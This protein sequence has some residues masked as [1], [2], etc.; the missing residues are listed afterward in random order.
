VKFS[1]V[2]EVP[3]AIA[4]TPNGGGKNS[5]G[6]TGGGNAIFSG[7]F[8]DAAPHFPI[9]VAPGGGGGGGVYRGGDGGGVEGEN[10][11][12]GG[13]SPVGESG[14]TGG[15]YS[16]PVSNIPQT[17]ITGGP[18]AITGGTFSNGSIGGLTAVGDLGTL[19]T[20]SQTASQTTDVDFNRYIM[21][22]GTLTIT[23]PNFI[24]TNSTASADI[25]FNLST[26]ELPP[27]STGT[28]YDGYTGPAYIQ[29][30]IN[31]PNP[32]TI[33]DNPVLNSITP[34]PCAPGTVTWSAGTV[35]IQA[36]FTLS[37]SAA[38]PY[39]ELVANKIIELEGPIDIQFSTPLT[40]ITGTVT[41]TG[42]WTI[43]PFGATVSVTSE[44]TTYYG[45][46]GIATYGATGFGNG[47]AG[48]GGHFGGGGGAGYTGNEGGGGAGSFYAITGGTGITGVTY[49]FFGGNDGVPYMNIYNPTEIYGAGGKSGA[50]GDPLV[51]IEWEDSSITQYALTV[52][53]NEVVSGLA[54]IGTSGSTATNLTVYGNEVINGT[55]TIGTN[56]GSELVLM[57]GSTMNSVFSNTNSLMLG[58]SAGGTGAYATLDCLTGGTGNIGP[59]IVTN[60]VIVAAKN[61]PYLV[62]SGLIVLGANSTIVNYGSWFLFGDMIYITG[63]LVATNPTDVT[64]L[65]SSILTSPPDIA[66]RLA[67]GFLAI[68]SVITGLFTAG[69]SPL[70]FA[71]YLVAVNIAAWA[72]RSNGYFTT[73]SITGQLPP[74]P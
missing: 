59:T 45:N 23:D 16:L 21:T 13:Y 8:P 68:P 43:P 9:L 5:D 12:F 67:G 17:F 7:F 46:D 41:S 36:P 62:R 69:D 33:Y 10:F 64:V 58:T 50:G 37:I 24:F 2:P 34:V 57:Q 31:T 15:I 61:N 65:F 51:V 54:T 1:F 32:P 22:A 35:V 11:P 72:V 47:G 28:T 56:I 14:G 19:F 66:A 20:F 38:G 42:V 70:V 49:S 48:G 30:D 60:A 3:G 29:Y 74:V 18:V 73:F 6:S 25:S 55:S 40:G 26:F 39:S 27:G 71:G 52:N 63:T 44:R 4:F 53:G